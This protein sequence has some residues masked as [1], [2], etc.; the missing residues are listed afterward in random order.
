[1]SRWSRSSTGSPGRTHPT[2]GVAGVDQ[3]PGGRDPV[4]RDRGLCAGIPEDHFFWGPFTLAQSRDIVAGLASL[5][6]R[7]DGM[8]GWLDARVPSQRDLAL[9]LGYAGMDPMRIRRWPDE[10]EMAELFQ[11]VRVAAAEYRRCRPAT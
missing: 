10:T 4:D 6:Y 8:G 5:G 9:A 1:M 2:A 7:F 11:N 3:Q